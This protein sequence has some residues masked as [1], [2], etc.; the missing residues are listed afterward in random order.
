MVLKWFIE[1]TIIAPVWNGD[2]LTEEASHL[3]QLTWKNCFTCL[4]AEWTWARG[5]YYSQRDCHNPNSPLKWSGNSTLN[6]CHL[7]E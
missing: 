4:S 6:S 7:H 5:D 2:K 3:V 1:S